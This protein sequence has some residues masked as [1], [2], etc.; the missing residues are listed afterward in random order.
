[1]AKSGN[2]ESEYGGGP[3]IGETD[4]DGLPRTLSVREEALKIRS[5]GIKEHG[6]LESPRD[7]RPLGSKGAPFGEVDPNE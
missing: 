4:P 6:I 3:G 5:A 7:V 2:Y 1:M